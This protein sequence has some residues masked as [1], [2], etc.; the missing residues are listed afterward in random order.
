MDFGWLSN[1][2]SGVDWGGLLGGL[3]KAAIPSIFELLGRRER[4]GR[5]PGGYPAQRIEQYGMYDPAIQKYLMEKIAGME[6]P[7]P[8]HAE[9]DV[10][11][12]RLMATTPG[13]EPTSEA[14]LTRFMSEVA[15]PESLAREAATVG[16]EEFGRTL[17]GKPWMAEGGRAPVI[18]SDI[19]RQMALKVALEKA[20]A[21]KGVPQLARVL[22]LAEAKR[23]MEAAGISGKLAL[24]QTGADIQKQ[25]I[26]A[27]MLKT[28]AGTHQLGGTVLGGV[29]AGAQ[30]G[31]PES[32]WGSL[33]GALGKGEGIS[34][35][36]GWLSDW[37]GGGDSYGGWPLYGEG[38]TYYPER[39]SGEPE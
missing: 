34:G 16:A 3:G 28:L 30:A 12:L 32:W 1:L 25:A 21:L 6:G 9:P 38:G 39:E 22:Q 27:Q 2:F 17:G 7:A 8:Y 4:A 15:Y 24:G 37:L 11:L 5:E 33:L 14:D 10:S 31:E 23:G 13:M 35:L 20:G 19:A 26:M 36:G 29:G 18:G